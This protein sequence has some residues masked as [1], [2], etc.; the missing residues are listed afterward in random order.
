M[1]AAVT[2]FAP[3][4]KA[5]TKLTAMIFRGM[6]NLGL[7]AAQSQGLLAK[8]GLD[9]EFKI[10]RGSEEA[11]SGLAAG[12]HQIVHN[13]IDNS[14]ALVETAGADSIV[15]VGGDSGYNSLIV[16][17]D[18]RSYEDMR[19]KTV[20]VDAPNTGFA[21]L[22]YD[23]LKQK[24]LKP[25]DYTPKPVGASPR[26]VEALIADKSLVTAVLNP[27]FSFHAMEAG[28]QNW[29]SVIAVI[30]GAYQA[31][32]GYVLRSWA[33]ANADT[34]VRYIR[35]YVEGVRWARDP[36]NRDG[37][38][39]L[40]VDH[41]KVSPAI[42]ARCYDI[43]SDPVNGLATD[44]QVSR[45]GLEAVLRLRAEYAGG[46]LST[47]DKYVDLTYYEKALAGL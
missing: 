46:H 39:A 16:Q 3:A 11:R 21:F 20:A 43:L 38:I 17:P 5:E 28:L 40:L 41:L 32:G 4:A 9:V 12:H 23:A 44:A 35:A 8:H 22:L 14:I 6:Q 30:G 45:K 37:A 33:E 27:P 29:G 18:L 36:A 47:P 26:R 7:L 1:T 42:A 13:A 2:A 25:G 34:L 24:G 10:A 19:G 15:V 31:T